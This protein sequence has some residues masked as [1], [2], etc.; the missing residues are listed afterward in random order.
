MSTLSV[1]DHA[2][3]KTRILSEQCS[4]CIM[5]P[6]SQRLPLTNMRL[7]QFIEGALAA[8]SYVVCHA[9]LPT[10]ASPGGPPEPPASG[11]FD[12]EQPGQ[13]DIFTFFAEDA[14]EQLQ[15]ERVSA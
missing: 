5:R 9:T 14:I 7:R 3:G 11:P 6:A 1:A 12:E 8:E 15:P 10:V 13:T 4:T 2:L